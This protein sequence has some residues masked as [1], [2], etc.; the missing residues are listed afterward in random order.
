M[1][2]DIFSF[3]STSRAVGANTIA[4]FFGKA[5]SAGSMFIISLLIARSFG[6]DGYG[7]FIK[8]TTYVAFYYL[9]ADFGLNAIYLQ[10]THTNGSNTSE[11]KM[12][13][14]HALLALRLTG[15][16]F[17]IFLALA[18]LSLLPQGTT[19]G[20]TGLVRLGIILYSPAIFLQALITTTNAV[21]Q[22]NL[23][24]DLAAIAGIIGSLLSL[25]LVWLATQIISV[26]TGAIISSLSLL[27]GTFA[28]GALGILFVSRIH[29]SVRLVFDTRRMRSLFVAGIPLGLMLLFNQVY[30]RIDS[31]ILTLTRSTTEV[32]VY[33]LAYRVFELPLVLPTFFMNAMYPVMLGKVTS[34]K[35]QAT[36]YSFRQLIL[37]SFIFLLI[38]SLLLLITLWLAAPFLSFIRPEFVQS[39]GAL[40]ILLLSLPFFFMTSLFM[41]VLVAVGKQYVLPIIYGVSMILIIFLDS[42]FI[43][44]FGYIAA[45]WI[46][47]FSEGFVLLLLAVTTLKY[48]SKQ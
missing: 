1:R 26:Q 27:I 43:P 18:V 32:G 22:K 12:D 40:R 35:Q 44:E 20:Y 30:F 28:T 46:T 6:A 13:T 16:L 3:G 4:Q 24:Y 2:I 19:Q 47:V 8:I 5:V 38:T 25:L 48:F 33:G 39:V 14:W 9:L 45:S 41:W 17:L 10:R 15:S 23:R 21:F 37:K 34:D 29:D 36:S 11:T 31:F 7:D 42:I